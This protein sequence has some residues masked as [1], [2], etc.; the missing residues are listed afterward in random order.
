MAQGKMWD[1]TVRGWRVA[2]IK[3]IEEL[4]K[5]PATATEPQRD[6]TTLQYED[7]KIGE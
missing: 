6:I 3:G 4:F 7:T 2:D 5:E 1:F